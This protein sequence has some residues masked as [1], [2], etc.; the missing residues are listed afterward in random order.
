MKPGHGTNTAKDCVMRQ[1]SFVESEMR[2]RGSTISMFKVRTISSLAT[3]QIVL[4]DVSQVHEVGAPLHHYREASRQKPKNAQRQGVRHANMRTS[5]RPLT[6]HSHL[7]DLATK[8]D[9]VLDHLAKPDGSKATSTFKFS[10][11]A[12]AGDTCGQ[13]N[14]TDL[15][16]PIP[17][18]SHKTAGT[19]TS[20]CNDWPA[21]LGLDQWLLAHLLQRYRTMQHHFPFVVVLESWDVPYMLR[22]QPTLFLAAAASA[23]CHYPVVQQA[24]NKELK[25]TL[26]RRVLVGGET[27]LEL[28]QTLLVYLAW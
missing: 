3:G 19:T 8:L 20:P 18:F 15:S 25:E 1:V 4:I 16:G 7:R 2:Q 21:R 26:A 12:G 13:S 5:R 17:G 9:G 22:S 23:A 10:F 11:S 6:R 28:L 27:S 24:L 14:G